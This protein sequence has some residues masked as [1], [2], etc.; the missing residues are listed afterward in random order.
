MFRLVPEDSFKRLVVLVENFV[1]VLLHGGDDQD[2]PLLGGVIL[3][4][5]VDTGGSV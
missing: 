5:E 3:L 1:L 2:E 4:I